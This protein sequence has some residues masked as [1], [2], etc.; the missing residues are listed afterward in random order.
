MAMSIRRAG[1]TLVLL[2]VA[3]FAM[4]EAYYWLPVLWPLV[5]S[6]LIEGLMRLFDVHTQE[7][8]AVVEYMSARVWFFGLLAVVYTV[9]A[10]IGRG[11]PA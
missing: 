8:D 1:V 9:A 5:P 10:R 3:S 4:A 6:W 2:V 7:E 11:E